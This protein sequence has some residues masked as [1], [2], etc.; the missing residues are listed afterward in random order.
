[1]KNTVLKIRKKDENL[2]SHLMLKKTLFGFFLISIL[3]SLLFPKNISAQNC[4]LSMMA[5]NNIESVNDEGR[6]Y[7]ITLQN[8]GNEAISV[9]LSVL[10]R[11]SEM[12][13]DQTPSTFNVS[14]TA[15]ILNSAGKAINGKVN[16]APKELLEFQVK[17]TVPQSTPINRWNHL[18]LKAATDKCSGYESTLTLYT[19]VPNPEEK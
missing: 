16:V 1:M 19:Y 5:Q 2:V 13:P 15:E 7:F 10:N 4:S 14:L 12:N 17:V 3:L 18:L 9:D 11:N 8:N 6:V